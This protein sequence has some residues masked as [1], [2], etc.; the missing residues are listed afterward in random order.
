VS[1]KFEYQWHQESSN[2]R[3]VSSFSVLF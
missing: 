1:L 3:F 2:N